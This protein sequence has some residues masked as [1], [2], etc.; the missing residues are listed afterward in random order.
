[1]YPSNN[2]GAKNFRGGIHEHNVLR[3]DYPRSPIHRS[4]QDSPCAPFCR[5]QFR[6][7]RKVFLDVSSPFFS[8]VAAGSSVH[9][10]NSGGIESKG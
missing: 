3:V 9:G 5:Q 6:C 1:M 2:S 7:R 8:M 4:I 10:Y